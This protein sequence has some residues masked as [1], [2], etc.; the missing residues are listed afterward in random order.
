MYLANEGGKLFPY[1]EILIRIRVC[2]N[3]DHG[4]FCRKP[5]F[6]FFH[7]LKLVYLYKMFLPCINLGSIAYAILTSVPLLDESK[8]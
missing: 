7:S 6:F 5:F 4:A 2:G 1:P 3:A 8:K